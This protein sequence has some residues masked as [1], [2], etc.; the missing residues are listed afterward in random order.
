MDSDNSITALFSS[1]DLM[2]IGAYE[3]VFNRGLSVPD[4]ISIVGHDNI[5]ISS[6]VRPK[7]TTI[8]TFKKNLGEAAVDLL[9]REMQ[10]LG[11]VSLEEVFRTELVERESVCMRR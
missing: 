4:D 8:N 5:R 7:L 9:M 6:L 3:A 11:G 1:H 2:A 10:G